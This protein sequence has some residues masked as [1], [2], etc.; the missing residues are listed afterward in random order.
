MDEEDYDEDEAEK[1]AWK[2][3]KEIVYDMIK[4]H[5]EKLKE[6]IISDEEEEEEIPF[7]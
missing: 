4:E 2:R 5:R 1:A 6:V 3:R 7:Y